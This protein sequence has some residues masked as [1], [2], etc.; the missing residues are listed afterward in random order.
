MN[1]STSRRHLSF[2]YP[3]PRRLGDITKL[4]LL[5]Q[6]E[7][8]VIRQIWTEFHKG[9]N[10]TIGI[11]LPKDKFQA[12]MAK[13]KRCPIF[14]LP[15]YRLPEHNTAETSVGE[16]GYFVLLSQFQSTHFLL[17]YLEDYKRNPTQA[18]P[19]MTVSTYDDL[20]ETKG[21]GLLRVDFTP[22][23][24]R[25]EANKVL[26][27][28]QHYYSEKG[29]EYAEQFNHTPAKFSFDAYINSIPTSVIS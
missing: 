17:T 16:A 19:Y 29:G 28:L 26:D 27:L 12:L 22:Q 11:T 7:P 25:V 23:L 4:P 15:V 10:D 13:A 20:V 21:L 5:Q 2:S 18:Q 9:R 1:S 3:G 8:E 14:I 24:S 6:E